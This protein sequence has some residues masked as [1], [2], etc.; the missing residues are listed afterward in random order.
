MISRL[1]A[2]ETLGLCLLLGGCG[3]TEPQRD[4]GAVPDGVFTTDATGYVAH[5][6]AESGAYVRYRF[7][8]ITR[9]ENRGTATL[10]LDRCLPTSPQPLFTVVSTDSAIESGYDY[11]WGCV[12]H[13]DQFE[14]PPGALRVDTLRVEGPNRFEQGKLTGIGATSGRF[15]L[16]FSVGYASSGGSSHA[17]APIRYSNEFLVHAVD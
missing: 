2:F 17:P 3:V 6:I 15:K 7:T 5:R 4:L 1:P 13:D 16:S 12:G 14:L 8:V 9:Y 10:I 11:V